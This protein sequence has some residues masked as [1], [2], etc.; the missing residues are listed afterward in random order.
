MATKKNL[1]IKNIKLSHFTLDNLQEAVLWIGADGKI[2]RV[3]ER[4]CELS[5]YT[6]EE[7]T[8]MNILQLNPT[9]YVANWPRYWEGL[10]KQKKLVFESQHQHK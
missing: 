10:K 1:D 2:L 4:T 7:L 6:R 9:S 5:G 8:G 3:N